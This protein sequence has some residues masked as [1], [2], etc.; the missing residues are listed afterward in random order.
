MDIKEIAK[1]AY[2]NNC[3]ISIRKNKI[4]IYKAS[5]IVHIYLCTKIQ[6]DNKK[7]LTINDTHLI[8]KLKYYKILT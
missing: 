1:L 5:N 8:D 2:E 4:V 7:H 6:V 3:I